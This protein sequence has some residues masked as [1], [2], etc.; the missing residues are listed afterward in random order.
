MSKATN[1]NVSKETV[2]DQLE[3]GKDFPVKFSAK[4]API[5]MGMVLGKLDTKE[6]NKI[7]KQTLSEEEILFLATMSMLAISSG[8]E[9]NCNLDFIKKVIKK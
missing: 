7:I 8:A 6:V 5:I 2:M 3:L 4:I 9:E 1:L